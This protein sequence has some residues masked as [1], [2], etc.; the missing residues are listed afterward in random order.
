MF[1]QGNVDQKVNL[2]VVFQ[3]LS[4]VRLFAT[5]WTATLQAPLSATVSP[6]FMAIEFVMPSKH[7]ILCCSLF[8]LPSII[9]SPTFNFTLGSCGELGTV[10]PRE[11]LGLFIQSVLS[12]NHRSSSFFCFSWGQ[13]IPQ[14]SSSLQLSAWFLPQWWLTSLSYLP[15][16]QCQ[17]K[18]KKKG[19]LICIFCS[20]SLN[21]LF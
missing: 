16:I 5:P 12:F 8:L 14:C 17:K 21:T 15:G 18:K 6:K 11:P 1:F 10:S 7:L 3:S 13:S 19:I 9:S 2:F 4:R 20:C